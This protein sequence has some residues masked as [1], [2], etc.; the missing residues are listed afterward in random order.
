M[1][2]DI[3]VYTIGIGTCYLSVILIVKVVNLIL[4]RQLPGICRTRKD[5]RITYD[6]MQQLSP[7][8]GMMI[9]GCI[10]VPIR[11]IITITI[12]IKCYS[13]PHCFHIVGTGNSMS[14]GPSFIQCR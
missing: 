14:I 4:K 8:T 7:D 1:T 5:F 2:C 10:P 9:R 13:S 3:K 6:T 12:S 11:N